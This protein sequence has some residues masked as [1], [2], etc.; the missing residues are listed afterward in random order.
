MAAI[1]QACVELRGG[2]AG[3]WLSFVGGP[4]T[5]YKGMT[6][7]QQASALLCRILKQLLSGVRVVIGET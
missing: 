3:P 7:G 6:S 4:H 2:W 1:L 5:Y